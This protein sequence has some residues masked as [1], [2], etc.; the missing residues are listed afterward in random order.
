MLCIYLDGHFLA[1][2]AGEPFLIWKTVY[3][4]LGATFTGRRHFYDAPT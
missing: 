1:A 2:S 4:F 3:G